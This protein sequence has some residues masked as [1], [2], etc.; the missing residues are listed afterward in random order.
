MYIMFLLAT[1]EGT[2]NLESFILTQR[3]TEKEESD[4]AAPRIS[5]ISDGPRSQGAR[6]ISRS[7]KINLPCAPATVHH[8]T[9]GPAVCFGF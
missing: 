1:T 7:P 4:S 6:D 9:L 2:K 8:L 3:N 5:P